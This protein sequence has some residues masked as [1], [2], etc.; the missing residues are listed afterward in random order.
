MSYLFKM[1]PINTTKPLEKW[2]TKN[3]TTFQ[4][5]FNTCSSLSDASGVYNW[6]MSSA[7]SIASMFTKCYAVRELKINNWDVSNVIDMSYMLWNCSG[8]T[9]LDLTSWNTSN[10]T[11]TQE[12]L[13][14][15]TRLNILKVGKGWDLTKANKTDM[16]TGSKIS[17][18]TKAE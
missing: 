10:V 5:M 8:L 7:K 12:M 15:T 9:E 11:T 4:G 14:Y 6:D 17:D 13:C 2:N 18:V 1:T 3:V 16:F